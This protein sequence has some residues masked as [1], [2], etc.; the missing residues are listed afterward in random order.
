MRKHFLLAANGGEKAEK[1]FHRLVR[2]GKDAVPFLLIQLRR[3]NV[4][5]SDLARKALIAIG[6]KA[7]PLLL[8]NLADTNYRFSANVA[9]ILGEIGNRKAQSSL[10]VAAR[11]GNGTL[12]SAAIFALG[13]LGDTLAVP[14]F[15]S[16][17]DDTNAVIRASSARALGNFSDLRA[18][19]KLFSLLSDSNLNVRTATEL[20]LMRF[21]RDTVAAFAL[22]RIDSAQSF[23]KHH[24]I[25]VLGA[26][27]TKTALAKLE[28]LL[29]SQDFYVR[30]FACEAL[31]FFRGKHEIANRIKRALW[32]NSGFVRM[33]ARV[34]LA[35]LK[36]EP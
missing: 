34:A 7:L 23:E 36:T 12:R 30:G 11:H 25:M 31:G 32:D 18:V 27:G 24:I 10:M 20:T 21:P 3:P 8:E 28:E 13:K 1:S 2:S 14:I 4:E 15:L 29:Q 6:D 5:K 16:G 19:P 26:T 33:K 22:S 17:L 35:K 9:E